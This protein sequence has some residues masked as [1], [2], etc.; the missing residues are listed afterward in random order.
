[1]SARLVLPG[2][3]CP[4]AWQ[5][6][7][8]LQKLQKHEIEAY[9]NEPS[10]K[11]GD[12]LEG[13]KIA[14]DPSEWDNNRAETLRK[15]LEEQKNAPVDELDEEEDDE[16][17]GKKRKR[18][19]EGLDKKKA[20]KKAPSTKVG[21][22]TKADSAGPRPKKRGKKNGI[23][24]SELIPESEDEGAEK[25]DVERPAKKTKGEED[26]DDEECEFLATNCPYFS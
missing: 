23:T 26:D 2:F 9:I 21:V 18:D 22:R 14:L 19:S 17:T 16:K 20:S 11:N 13:Y 25:R 1:V 7:A 15:Y 10:K 6:I 12:L 5:V 4:S 8:G 3:L 24:S